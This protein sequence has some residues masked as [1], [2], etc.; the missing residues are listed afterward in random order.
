MPRAALR[1]EEV[2]DRLHSAAIRL[3]RAVRKADAASGISGAQLSALSVLVFG[4][5][6]TLGSLAAIE[7]V[8]PPTM[9]QLVGA[10][11]ARGLVVRR[12]L[13]RRS[14]EVAVT[15]KGRRLMEAGRKRRL[16]RL[17]RSLEG[18]APSKLALLDEAARIILASADRAA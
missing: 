14:I 1:T 18:L 3:L 5:A 12:P 8:K 16:A 4:G 11:E 7:Q 10:L 15:D 13:D 6:Q 9:S 2:A 17:A